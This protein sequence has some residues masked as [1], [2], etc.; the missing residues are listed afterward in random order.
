MSLKNL[1]IGT[2]LVAFLALFLALIVAFFII[3]ANYRDQETDPFD[4]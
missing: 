2:K 1:G 3:S 4:C